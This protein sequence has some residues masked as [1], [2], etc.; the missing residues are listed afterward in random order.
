MERRDFMK[1]TAAGFLGAG[2]AGCSTGKLGSIQLERK[3]PP[4]SFGD[5]YPRPKGGTIPTGELGT[6]GI[7]VSKFGFGSHIRPY[8]VPYVRERERMLRDAFELGVRVFDVYDKE[9]EIYQYEPT[10]RH[11][12]PVI[13]DVVIS[14]AILPYDGRT[15]QEE[16]ER[17]LRVFGRDYLDMVRIH[18]YS[19]DEDIWWQWEDLFKF[20]EQGKIRAVGVPIHHVKQLYPLIDTYPIDYV[21]FPYNFYHNVIWQGEVAEGDFDS[22]PAMLRKRGIGVVTMKAFAGDYLVTPLKEVAET[23]K[24]DKEI[25]FVQAALRY[26]I[27]S[28]LNPDTTLT[29]MYYPSDVYENVD[30]FYNPEMSDEEQELLRKVDKVAKVNADAWLPE[31]YKFLEEWAPDSP[32]DNWGIRYL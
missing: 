11:L 13:N 15:L 7:K 9:F 24:E 22:L 4:F 30:A 20:K 2:L 29:G 16:L 18:S 19:P 6:T 14:I 26:V 5:N 3:L 23:F 17:D 32:G 12:A 21:I 8:L 27:N 10:G 28:G 1:K 31:H 25:S